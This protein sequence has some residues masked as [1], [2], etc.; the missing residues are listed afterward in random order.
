MTI[1]K[2]GF[3]SRG[4]SSYN[5]IYGQAPPERSIFFRLRVYER[6]G[7][8]LVEVCESVSK[9][10]FSVGKITKVIKMGYRRILCETIF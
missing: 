4:A 7:L 1:M 9:S 3:I 6:V 5:D 2:G 8:L 10:V